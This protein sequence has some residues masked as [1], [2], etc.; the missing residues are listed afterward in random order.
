MLD[1]SGDQAQI[2]VECRNW[3]MIWWI[4]ASAKNATDSRYYLAV[5]V[6]TSGNGKQKQ[7]YVV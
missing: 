6:E 1:L 4:L 7:K 2:V 5:Q 3:D